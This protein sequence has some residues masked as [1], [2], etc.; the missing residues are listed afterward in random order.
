MLDVFS[1]LSSSK[2]DFVGAEDTDDDDVA[3]RRADSAVSLP[4]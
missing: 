4:K 3:G 2:Y 1:N